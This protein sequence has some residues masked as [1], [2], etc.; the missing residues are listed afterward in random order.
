MIVSKI[1][2]QTKLVNHGFFNKKKGFSN[3]IYKS[4]NCGKESKDKK[5]NNKKNLNYVKK[6][7]KSKKNNIILLHQIHSS[8]YFFIKKKPK[9]KNYR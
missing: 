7:I 4:L 1:L 5:Y 8:N 3:G 2:Y 6:K 9:K